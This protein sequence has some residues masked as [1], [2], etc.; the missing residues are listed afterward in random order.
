LEL[1]KEQNAKGEIP[2]DMPK[3]KKFMHLLYNIWDAVLTDQRD[4]VIS[5]IECGLYT[6]N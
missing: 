2:M 5:L 6:V 4:Y 1:R 3:A